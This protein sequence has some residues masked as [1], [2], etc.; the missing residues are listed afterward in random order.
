[1]KN[2]K[3][4][5]LIALAFC[6][7]SSAYPNIHNNTNILSVLEIAEETVKTNPELAFYQE[8]INGAKFDKAFAA[9]FNDPE[10]SFDV[11]F[12]RNKDGRDIENG[13]VWQVSVMQTFE[14][15][16]RISLRKSIA[17]K[18][19][20]LAKLGLKQF[21]N[22]LSARAKLLAFG[23]YSANEKAAAIAEVA[24]RYKAL[25]ETF[26]QREPSGI[27]P[28][29]QTRVIEAAEISLNRSAA[30]AKLAVE[31]A[32]IE[33]NLLRGAKINSPVKVMANAVEFKALPPLEELLSS[34]EK[35]NYDYRT[36]IVELEQQ[37]YVV[38]LSRNERYPSISAGPYVSMDKVGGNETIIG[39]SV[40]MP[41]PITGRQTAL[42]NSALSKKRQTQTA[43]M[44]AHR[45]LNR[46][47]IS[48][49]KT[50]ETKLADLK[51]WKANSVEKFREASELADRHFRMGAIDIAVYVEV[52]NSYLSAVESLLNTQSEILA[53]AFE[54]QELTGVDLTPEQR[55]EK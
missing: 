20:E 35:F 42:S 51:L 18:N 40:S 27:S 13:A 34:A 53:A 39:L 36:K 2:I 54:L 11:G 4:M 55:S 12:K 10:L 44:L 16:G 30:D 19:V 31:N 17:Q 43:V 7:F 28:L 46:R 9:K 50:Y 23:L 21:K 47:V 29:M 37:G 45:E 33:L 38:E 49:A 6:A 26:L 3:N 15:P 8:A 24:E 14:W 25:R 22:A 48:A 1:M 32:L 5:G 41:L 52:Q